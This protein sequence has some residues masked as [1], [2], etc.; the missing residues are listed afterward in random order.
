MTSPTIASTQR[1]PWRHEGFGPFVGSQFVS[2]IGDRIATLAYVSL[3]AVAVSEHS[4][5]AAANVAA[6]QIVPIILLSYFGGILSDRLNRKWL[7]WWVDCGRM[8]IVLAFVAFFAGREK[9]TSVYFAVFL[10]G[11][12]SAVFNPAKRSF[13]PFLVPHS[14]IRKA[15]WHV[16]VSEVSAMILGIGAGTL[17]LRAVRPQAA[18]AFDVLSFAVALAILSWVPGRLDQGSAKQ[19]N[20]VRTEEFR[21]AWRLMVVDGTLRALFVF[22]VLPFYLAS[23]LY[24]AAATHWAVAQNPGNA[25]AALGP[26]FLSLSGGALVSFVIRRPL[27]R[28]GERWSAVFAFV[29]GAFALTVQGALGSAGIGIAGPVAAVFGL[30]MGLTYARSMYLFQLVAPSKIIG[31]VMSVKEL[32]GAVSFA[33]MI[34]V[35]GLFSTFTPAGGWFLASCLYLLGGVG[36][37]WSFR[38]GQVLIQ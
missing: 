28:M 33:G 21:D 29:L 5:A 19:T 22:L 35:T 34:F 18:L 9:V 15:N 25:G 7:M 31:R 1:S 11:A 10:L 37:A 12:L 3:A 23:G 6:V 16:V 24:Y 17:L 8:M 2:L 30:A 36:M 38:Q 20:D 13:V 26:L 4:G 27:E 14:L 32:I